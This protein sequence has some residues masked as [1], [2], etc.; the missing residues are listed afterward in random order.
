MKP[1]NFYILAVV[2]VVLTAIRVSSSSAEQ[3]FSIEFN[4]SNQTLSIF[5]D[6]IP[7]SVI[8]K[9]IENQA[10]CKIYLFKDL[11]DVVSV[12]IEKFPLDRAIQKIAKNYSMAAIYRIEP[13]LEN[14]DSISKIEEI[15]LFKSNTVSSEKKPPERIQTVQTSQPTIK[16]KLNIEPKSKPLIKK[17]KKTMSAKELQKLNMPTFDDRD[18]GFWANRLFES[19]KY[20]DKEQSV[21]EL[22]RIGSKEA[23]AAMTI[24]LGDTDG[25]LRK[26]TVESIK[27]MENEDAWQIIGQTFLGDKDIEVRKTALEYFF[28]QSTEISQAILNT[29]I[30][31]KDPQIRA[32]AKKALDGF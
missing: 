31:D 9:E 17:L 25:Q 19:G 13:I 23:L 6:G 26:F 32:M 18:V 24:A 8:L 21:I 1:F 11:D 30:K 28:N 5:S 27:S 29:A 20:D 10:E 12:T 2:F 7:L 22:K 15:W 3:T 14:A 4:K 16:K